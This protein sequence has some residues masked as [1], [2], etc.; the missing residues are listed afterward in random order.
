MLEHQ[1][2]FPKKKV[3][4]WTWDI[5]CT[6]LPIYCHESRRSIVDSA[7]IRSHDIVTTSDEEQTPPQIL[8]P[9][10]RSRLER[11]PLHQIC[12]TGS[13]K[14]STTLIYDKQY[15]LARNS[16]ALKFMLQPFVLRNQMDLLAVRLGCP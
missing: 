16:F 12:A 2:V 7:K 4:L 5:F 9:P 8:P 1:E 15:I 6:G 10:I 3:K 13:F 11:S 14:V